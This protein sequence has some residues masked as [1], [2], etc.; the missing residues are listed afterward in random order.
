MHLAFCCF[1]LRHQVRGAGYGQWCVSRHCALTDQLGEKYTDLRVVADECTR[2][3]EN[4]IQAWGVEQ[5]EC[6]ELD[7]RL[8]P[9]EACESSCGVAIEAHS[10]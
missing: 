8:S 2:L 9:S 3:V 5:T 6:G 7:E 1:G 10:S 4:R